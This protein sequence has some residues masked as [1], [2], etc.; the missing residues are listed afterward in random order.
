MNFAA[1]IKAGSVV[2][3][4]GTIGWASWATTDSLGIRPVMKREFMQ[5]AQT[6]TD[7]MQ[8]LQETQQKIIESQDAIEFRMLM[9]KQ[10]TG[11]LS[12]DEKR[13]LCSL[14]A[15]FNMNREAGC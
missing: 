3:A 12:L 4:I 7:V 2:G 15:Q 14:A 13:Q 5:L 11:P 8:Q 6:Q 10:T 1:I 9:W